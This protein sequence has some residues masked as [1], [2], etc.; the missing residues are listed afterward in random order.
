MEPIV[1]QTPLKTSTLNVSKRAA[2]VVSGGDISKQAK[3]DGLTPLAAE[4]PRIDKEG[5]VITSTTAEGF[6]CK[7][8]DTGLSVV[9]SDKGQEISLP[10]GESFRWNESGLTPLNEE[11]SKSASL[12]KTADGLTLISF[13][14]KDGNTVQIQPDSL[15]YEVLNKQKNL[16]QVYHPDGHQEV[17]AFGKFRGSDGKI[18]DYEHHAVYAP[19]G[20]LVASQGFNG[21]AVDG[22][23]LTFDLG[24]GVRTER[25]LAKPLPGQQPFVQAPQPSPISS[26]AA[27]ALAIF[28]TEPLL[29]GNGL[30]GA[31]AL[32]AT[33][34]GSF[35]E[36]AAALSSA[37]PVVEEN[38]AATSSSAAGQTAAPGASAAGASAAAAA[39][40]AVAPSNQ[41][42]RLELL[43][44]LKDPRWSS[45]LQGSKLAELRWQLESPNADVKGLL[46]QAYGQ[47]EG[48]YTAAH[49]QRAIESIGIPL[50]EAAGLSPE[51]QKAV[52]EVGQFYDIGKLAVPQEILDFPGKWPDDKRGE[53]A[54]KIGNHVHPDLLAPMMK[55][56]GISEKGQQAILFHHQTP[57]GTYHKSVAAPAYDQLS[58][59]ARV[60]GL[61]DTVDAMLNSKANYNRPEARALTLDEVEGRL[62]ADAEKGKVDPDLYS[63]L[64]GK[65]IPE[66]K[67][68][69][70]VA[71][72]QALPDISK[73]FFA[74][75]DAPG[76][77]FDETPSKLVMRQE[78]PSRAFLLPNG[79]SF[80]TDGKHLQVLGEN[81]RVKNPRIVVEGDSQL[82]A[83]SDDHGNKH[84]LDINTGDYEV[85]NRQG[86]LTQ[87]LKADGTHDYGVRGTFTTESGK[88]QQYFMKA[89]FGEGGT[90]LSK[91]GFDDLRIQG[92]QMT[93]SLPN[94]VETTRT[95]I[96][97]AEMP[98]NIPKK[99]V[100]SGG[101]A[102]EW[103]SALALAD[104]FLNPA[105]AGATV[106]AGGQA[107]TESS[108]A[109]PETSATK[110]TGNAG[111]VKTNAETQRPR[112]PGQVRQPLPDGS[113]SVSTLP[114]GIQIV[115]GKE[116]YATDPAGKRLPVQKSQLASETGERYLLSVITGDGIGYTIA[117]DNL[118]LIVQSPDG[119]VHQL[120]SPN[121]RILTS[122]MDPDTGNQHLH[123]SDPFKGAVGSPGTRIDPRFPDR[124]FVDGSPVGSYKV[125]HPFGPVPGPVP[126]NSGQMPPNSGQVPPDS[127]Q[128]PPNSGQVPPDSGQNPGWAR[129]G[130]DG[131]D[132]Q[133]GWSNG[134]SGY[135]AGAGGVQ[136]GFQPNFWQRLK[137]AFTNENPWNPN[138]P[139]A[140]Q[141]PRNTRYPGN[142]NQYDPVA[143]QWQQIQRNNQMMMG[144]MGMGMGGMGMGGMGMGMMNQMSMMNMMFYSP[145]GMY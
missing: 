140:G 90:L 85:S 23:K 4:T 47:L 21:L 56:L 43:D 100:L 77:T 6:L 128:V 79:D 52:A 73:D 104:S 8:A 65:M 82:L 103:G 139:V 26:G 96:D 76:V 132:P 83:Y 75:A 105:A 59:A 133:G 17:V 34:P 74:G 22:R 126:P 18:T 101:V 81:P 113:G 88:P 66:M 58:P 122:I 71:E 80:R 115:D 9:T 141:N 124:I 121:G 94:G 70:S 40:A 97:A 14:D 129:G 54:E 102:E 36:S 138:D 1:G 3:T 45:Q 2:A 51:D 130:P 62:K 72:F 89:S 61:A 136:Q 144:G 125:P 95:L 60:V 33:S 142:Y 84:T 110:P 25:V 35:Q 87:G 135:L 86:T 10:S 107:G 91:E 41:E 145:F 69:A 117:N 12:T 114:N 63:T 38:P 67:E 20:Q 19:D 48:G 143:A 98:V 11:S 7:T 112:A 16:A 29:A 42:S 137:G 39:T 55:A 118:D 64:F 123:E 127:G 32:Q 108:N 28:G 5:G 44:L 106:S 53:W 78:G 57:N 30:N 120:V 50:A 119:K 116:I 68:A 93:F 24:T 37:T 134:D 46:T 31:T 49:S 27:N 111:D 99:L 15:T 131:Q 109:S 92:N 13:Q